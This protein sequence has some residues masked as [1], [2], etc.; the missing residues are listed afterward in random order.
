MAAAGVF[1]RRTAVPIYSIFNHVRRQKSTVCHKLIVTQYG[2]P[3]KS[4][5]MV[6]D[7][8]PSLKSDEVK[9]QMLAA[10][11]NP[12]DINTIQGSYA[13]KP[14][15]PFIGGN[16]G[17]GE[18]VEVGSEVTQLKVGDRVLPA[19]NAW[20]TWRT[21][22]V[23]PQHQIFKVSSDLSPVEAATLSVNP[24]TAYRMLKDFVSLNGGDVVIQNGANSAVGQS[25]IQ[26]CKALGIK[27]VNIVRNRP[28][29]DILKQELE[30]LGADV[31]LTEEELRT[32]DIFKSKS[33]AKPVLGLNCVGG[34]NALE[35]IRQ[36]A[37]KGVLVTY[38]GMSR[39]PLTVPTTALIFKDLRFVGYWMTR[40]NKENQGSEKWAKMYEDIT[41]MILE[42]KLQPPKHRLVPFSDFKEAIDNAMTSKG[43]TGCK[44]IF[45]MKK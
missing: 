25:V 6:E 8:L 16:E 9:V 43:F 5:S 28:D 13:V 27:S 24:C 21:Y 18:I 15:I 39:E 32:T 1:L 22:A 29:I 4:L 34:K 37:N 11:V 12:A 7:T 44:Y 20:G 40:W 14:D 36:L 19:I 30:N 42:K 3:I 45:D 10:T 41:W 23:C 31:V 17:V 35:V 38:G 33:V 26:M 2:E